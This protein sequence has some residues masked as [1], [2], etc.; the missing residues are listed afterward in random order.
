MKIKNQLRLFLIGVIAVPPIC[1]LFLPIYHWY[2][3][4]ERMLINSYK[5]VRKFSD[6]PVSKRDISVLQELLKTMPPEVELLLVEDHSTILMTTMPDFKG[7]KNIDDESLFSYIKKTSRSYFYQMVT[8]PL[9]ASNTEIMLISRVPRERGRPPKRRP[10]IPRSLRVF[11]I[12]FV[13]FC[14]I[15]I[16]HISRTITRSITLLEDNAQRIADGELDVTLNTGKKLKT[17]NEITKL[18]E[19][20]DKMRLALKD[21]AERRTRF[22]M[23][24][25]HDLRTPVAVIKGYT[26]AISDGVISDSEEMK[27]SLD[28]IQSKTTQLETMIDTLIN[29]V[30]LNNADWRSQLKMQK[31]LPFLKEFAESSVTT[32]G[33]FKRIV[34]AEIQISP[35]TATPFD[36]QLFQRALENIF[37]NA[38]RYT[39]END[40]ITISAYEVTLPKTGRAAIV[41]IED[42]GAGIDTKDKD[43]I[44]DLFYRGTNSRRESGMGIGLSVVKNIID[45]HGWTIGVQSQKGVGTAFSITIPI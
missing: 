5:Q 17:T 23:G 38:L 18:S 37:S 29:F 10:M 22:I 15:S 16:I 8:P 21:A 1:A 41:K 13:L 27:R 11:L 2:T 25:S 7:I 4:P 44:F 42:S 26:E 19:N 40:T 3:R 28:I 32:G 45:T 30:K 6:E 20:L 9:E 14:I 36:S 39:Q 24:I 31:L 34:S 33:I 12:T 43:H 35:E